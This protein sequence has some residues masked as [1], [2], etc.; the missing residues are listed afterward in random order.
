MEQKH[1]L[2]NDVKVIFYKYDSDIARRVRSLNT[3]NQE[4]Y[5]YKEN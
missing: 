5:A 3:K 2:I 1:I 4:I